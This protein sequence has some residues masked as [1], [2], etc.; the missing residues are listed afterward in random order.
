MLGDIVAGLFVGFL[1]VVLIVLV[2]Y[3]WKEIMK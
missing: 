3:T 1:I 2:Y